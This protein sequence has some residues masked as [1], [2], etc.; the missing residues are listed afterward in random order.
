M[1]EPARDV[2]VRFR[3]ELLPAHHSSH[4]TPHPMVRRLLEFELPQGTAQWE[5]TD[6][7]H[8]GRFNPWE[9]RRIDAKLQ[10]RTAELQAVADALTT[11]V[12]GG[13]A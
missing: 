9:H 11:L 3:E 6:Y 5:Q 4:G 13:A 7:G 2:V 1:P 10:A 8:P 12:G